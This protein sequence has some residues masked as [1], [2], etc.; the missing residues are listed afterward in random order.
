VW[1]QLRTAGIH[2]VDETHFTTEARNRVALNGD[3]THVAEYAGEIISGFESAYRFLAARRDAIAAS[4]GPLGAFAR[5]RTRVIP[6]PTDQYAMLASALLGP[7]YQADG[8]RRSAA[9]DILARPFRQA[10]ERPS[11]WPLLVEERRS[12]DALDVPYFWVPSGGTDV[13]ADDRVVLPDYFTDSG[14]SAVRARISSFE[15][16]DL[17]RHVRTLTRALSESPSARLTAPAPPPTAAS[18]GEPPG[19]D[20]IELARWLGREIGQLPPPEGLALYDGAMGPAI[21]LSALAAVTGEE[22]WRDATLE[23]LRPVYE[24]VQQGEASELTGD[25]VGIGDG[26]GSVIYGL[27]WTSQLIGD[28]SPLAV[29]QELAG[30]LA[31]RI[32]SDA[33]DDVLSGSAGAALALLALHARAPESALRSWIGACADRLRHRQLTRGETACWPEPDGRR[34]VGF[35]HGTAGIGFALNR[36]ANLLADQETQ[37]VADAAV[38]FTHEAYQA[39]QRNWPVAL[40]AGTDDRAGGTMMTAWCHGAPGIALAL[41]ESPDRLR[42]PPLIEA[43]LTETA[44]WA[45]ARADHLCC[46]TLGRADVLLTV[47]RRLEVQAA[48]DAGLVLAARVTA[49]ARAVG[50]FRLSTPGFEYR[51]FDPGFFRGLAGIGYQ[52]LRCANPVKVP[53]I[54]A[55]DPPAGPDEGNRA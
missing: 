45:P 14:L 30:A 18:A 47:G 15:E 49:R 10:V 38:R 48:V 37:R 27:V 26:L 52:L 1:A 8:A 35:A 16:A 13:M 44:N 50:H 5:C 31:D 9:I 39:A 43:A 51:V 2:P 4:D 55:F 28:D 21:F 24:A 7:K 46:G 36:V 29:A 34:L 3:D 19:T 23:A 33:Y 11:V 41:A 17:E 53:S 12:L 25:R 6:R 40:A 20:L 54:L 22:E 32:E 42:Q